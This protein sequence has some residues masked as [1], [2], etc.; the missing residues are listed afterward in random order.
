ME[1]AHGS[2]FADYNKKTGEQEKLLNLWAL[3]G[4]K[5]PKKTAG[6]REKDMKEI[7]ESANEARKAEIKTAE[8]N[9]KKLK[10]KAEKA[11]Q[12]KARNEKKRLAGDKKAMRAQE[13]KG[14]S[15]SAETKVRGGDH[16][17]IYTQNLG[18]Q[19]DTT[20]VMDW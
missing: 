17:F 19:I 18:L 8:M 20:I 4:G 12:L 13:Q 5:P 7:M 16:S 3:L 6:S 1:Q 2:E 9:Q 14:G 10:L 15:G 11:K